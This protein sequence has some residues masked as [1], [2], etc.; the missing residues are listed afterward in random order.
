MHPDKPMFGR[1]PT[2][3]ALVDMWE[4]QAYEDGLM[5][6]AESFRNGPSSPFPYAIPGVYSTGYVSLPLCL[7]VC[8][9]VVVVVHIYIYIYIYIFSILPLRFSSSPAKFTVVIYFYPT[10]C[11][12]V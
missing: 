2:E 9:F 10:K 1:T 12:S 3:K 7:T 6:A 5:A 8:V 11:K 4:H